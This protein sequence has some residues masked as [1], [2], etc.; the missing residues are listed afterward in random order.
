MS[1][2]IVSKPGGIVG[3]RFAVF[4]ISLLFAATAA[5]WLLTELFPRDFSRNIEIYRE[6][7]G[8]PAVTASQWLR[9]DDPFH[10]AWYT[11][12]LVLFS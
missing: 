5:G 10:S 2:K 8:G 9:L 3:Q 12:L 1:L 6:S 4:V 7:W 11:A